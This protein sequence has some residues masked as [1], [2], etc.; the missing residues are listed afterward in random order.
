MG[1]CLLCQE[2]GGGGGGGGI[3][4]YVCVFQISREVPF[5]LNLEGIDLG[6]LR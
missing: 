1:F 2:S 6:L 3:R 4:G 5:K